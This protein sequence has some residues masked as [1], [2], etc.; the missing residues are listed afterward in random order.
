MA[1]VVDRMRGRNCADCAKEKRKICPEEKSLAVRFPELAAQY[2][3]LNKIPAN[4]LYPSYKGYIIWFCTEAECGCWHMW[5]APAA[6][7]CHGN[8]GCPYCCKNPKEFCYHMSIEV[9]HPDLMKE[10][11]PDNETEASQV[12]PGSSKEKLKWICKKAQCGCIHRWEATAVTRTSGSGCPFCSVPKKQFCEHESVAYL[13]PRLLREYSEN[14]EFPL[15]N[16]S[17]G[18][19]EV[20]EWKCHTCDNFWNAMINARTAGKGTCGFCSHSEGERRISMYF[21]N[22]DINF[23]SQKYHRIKGHRRFYDFFVKLYNLLVEFDGKQH[24]EEIAYFEEGRSFEETRKA[25]LQKNTYAERHNI[26]LLRISY[27]DIN[28][29]EEILDL[30]FGL[31]SDEIFDQLIC[32]PDDYYD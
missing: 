20:V 13:F 2:S 23:E 24:F 8:K 11:D 7:R 16:Y 10:Y 31:L 15:K 17:A 4:Q 30:V 32:V 21:S 9:T 5:M 19:N 3:T 1:V 27:R 25:D 26:H 29:I 14:N 22:R 6:G 12:L 18:S 28:R